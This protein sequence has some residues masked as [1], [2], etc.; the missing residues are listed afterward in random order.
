MSRSPSNELPATDDVVVRPAADSSGR[1]VLGTL[2]APGQFLC[3]SYDEA[4]ARARTYAK[5]S[6]VRVWRTDDDRTF[7]R[8]P[9][10]ALAAAA[11]ARAMQETAS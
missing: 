10:S 2:Q 11:T 5:R 4:I 6:K 8:V 9:T 1:Y 7:T 3:V